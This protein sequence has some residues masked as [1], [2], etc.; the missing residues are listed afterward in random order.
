MRQLFLYHCALIFNF[1]SL[2]NQVVVNI[3]STL[4]GELRKCEFVAQVIC[5]CKDLSKVV[6]MIFTSVVGETWSGGSITCLKMLKG[7]IGVGL[8][9]LQVS[10]GQ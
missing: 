2:T 5:N 10:K 1:L 4:F 3:G 9:T 6:N 7:G 8:T